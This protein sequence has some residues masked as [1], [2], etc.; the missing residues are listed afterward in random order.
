MTVACMISG[1]EGS[2]SLIAPVALM[3]Q[4]LKD[5]QLSTEQSIGWLH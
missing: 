5:T 2:L 4:I 3:S 1:N